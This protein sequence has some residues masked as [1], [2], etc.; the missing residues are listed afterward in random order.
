MKSIIM[1][2]TTVA[3]ASVMDTSVSGPMG[4]TD[5]NAF[6]DILL[7]QKQQLGGQCAPHQ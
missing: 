6:S 4:L 7:C 5:I 3:A 1:E 2:S